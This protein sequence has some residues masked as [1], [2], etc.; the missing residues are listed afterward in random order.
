MTARARATQ[1]SLARTS[2]WGGARPGA[3]R[4]PTGERAGTP[5]LARP[6]H[7][8]GHPVHATIRAL[9]DLGS[10]RDC[11]VYPAVEAA[12][13][14]ASRPEFR[15]V[16]FSVQGD[17]LH[18]IIEAHDREAL[19]RG[20]RGLV[21]RCARAINR[22]LGRAG[23]VWADR[24]HVRALKTPREVRNVLVY[25]LQNWR[26]GVR[27]AQGLDPCSSALWFDGWKGPRPAWA[28]PQPGEPPPVR[29]ARTWLLATAW[30]RHGLI[31]L[32]E[33]PRGA[34]D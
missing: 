10:L 11:P 31:G 16:E 28:L 25:V 1:L 12:I 24:Y 13:A 21:I 19:M 22:A 30:R 26:K 9:R 2:G 5:H 14:A 23:R 34:L 33:R 3:G 17:H 27:G 32:T 4:R 15:V 7:Y 18:L 6:R 29:A 20:M 8:H